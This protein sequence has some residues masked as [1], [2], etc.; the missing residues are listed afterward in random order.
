[1]IEFRRSASERNENSKALR[2]ADVS[3]AAIYVMIDSIISSEHVWMPSLTL[4][5]TFS[6]LV[7]D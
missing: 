4:R 2:R 1:M 7:S 5:V 6:Y 3:I